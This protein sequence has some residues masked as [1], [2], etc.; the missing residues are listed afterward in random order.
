MCIKIID[1]NCTC[2]VFSTRLDSEELGTAETPRLG[3]EKRRS[4]HA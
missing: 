4:G 1:L 3:E 2:P